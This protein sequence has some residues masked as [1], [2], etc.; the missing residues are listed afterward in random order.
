MITIMKMTD[1][2]IA[3]AT[4]A[5]AMSIAAWMKAHLLKISMLTTMISNLDTEIQCLAPTPVTT[6][7]TVIVETMSTS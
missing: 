4:T 6:S 7:S 1:H 5:A 2:M 3:V